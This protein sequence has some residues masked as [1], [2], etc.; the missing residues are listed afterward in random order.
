MISVCSGATDVMFILDA[1]GSINNAHS[2][3]WNRVKSFVGNFTAS[4]LSESSSDNRVGIITYS[5][6]GFVNFNLTS[7]RDELLQEID[8]LYYF[9]RYTNTA[10]GLCKLTGQMWEEDNLRLVIVMTDGR[11]N[12]NSTECGT[13]IDAPE[14]VDMAICPPP[15]YYVIGVTDNVVEEELE[16]I[17]TA[18]EFIDYLDAIQNTEGLAAI[19]RHR[20]YQICFRGIVISEMS[21][22]NTTNTCTGTCA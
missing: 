21:I 3:N 13:V 12:R 18:P 8:N 7:D 19:R 11:S 14:I 15:L 4:L 1:S 17:A 10:D 16:A 5:D 6:Y 9:G 22:I 20:A 2:E